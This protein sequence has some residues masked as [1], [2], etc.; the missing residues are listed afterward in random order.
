MAL[1]GCYRCLKCLMVVFNILYWALGLSVIVTAIVLLRNGDKYL[2]NQGG[3]D[4]VVQEFVVAVYALFAIGSFL[5]ILGFL[6]CCGA[7]RE[8]SCMLC[9]FFVLMLC[10][11]VVELGGGA[12]IWSQSEPIKNSIKKQFS[13]V[14]QEEYSPT[15]SDSFVN[16]RIDK[17]Q[18]DFQCCGIIDPDDWARSKYNGFTGPRTGLSNL[19]GVVSE[20][21][22]AYRVPA[23]CCVSDNPTVCEAARSIEAIGSVTNGVHRQGCLS[24]VWN[25]LKFYASYAGGLIVVA[26]GFEIIGLVLALL[27]CFAARRDLKD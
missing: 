16:Q 26:I 27:L 24:A 3:S 11:I 23:S 13:A 18:R 22:G 14:I 21:I 6:G 1:S 15:D 7:I 25:G 10:T 2:I 8:S 12:Q 19:V 17:F 20:S 9:T 4:Q 5:V